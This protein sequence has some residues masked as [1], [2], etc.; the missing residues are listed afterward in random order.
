MNS[1]YYQLND[2]KSGALHSSLCPTILE[3]LGPHFD[4]KVV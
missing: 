3:D 2:F 1:E 4:V